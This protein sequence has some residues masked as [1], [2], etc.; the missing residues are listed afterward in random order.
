[1]ILENYHI[2]KSQEIINNPR[3]AKE[4]CYIAHNRWKE[5]AGEYTMQAD[6]T[7]TYELYNLFS[8]TS[9]MPFFYEIYKEVCQSYRDWTGDTGPAWM[10]SWL[11]SHKQELV[12]DWHDHFGSEYHGYITIDSR[13]NIK[14]KTK[15]HNYEII[16]ELG[17]IYIGHCGFEHKVVVQEPYEGIR[18]T[19]A[20]QITRN[21]QLK[22]VGIPVF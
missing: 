6:S 9:G 10:M 8:I 15:F 19:I 12:L 4:Q 17:N 21:Q 18:H 20:F 2:Y 14:T 5:A 7:G 3:K 1:M 11:N 13:Q 16:N 22:N